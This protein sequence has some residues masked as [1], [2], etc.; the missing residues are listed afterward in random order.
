MKAK[1]HGNSK[2]A[3]PYFRTSESTKQRIQELATKS[4]PKSAVHKLTQEQGG[5][6]EARGSVFLPHNRQQ[7]ANFRRSVSKPKDSNVLYS[8]MVECKL[9]QGKE[10]A[11]IR[12]VKAIPEP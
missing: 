3:T 7:I 2:H 6:I 10:N 8:I 5:E 4:T 12:D 9:T 11:F 1:P